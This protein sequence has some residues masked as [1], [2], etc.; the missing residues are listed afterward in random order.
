MRMPVISGFAKNI[1]A[2]RTLATAAATVVLGVALP[3]LSGGTPAWACGDP[4]LDGAKDVPWSTPGVN[5]ASKFLRNM[6]SSISADGKWHEIA[7]EL[8]N[9]TG[10]GYDNA[11]PT[12]GF[13]DPK[14]DLLRG[15][16]IQVQA[17]QGDDSRRSLPL[18]PGCASLGEVEIDTS[19]LGQHIDNNGAALYRFLVKL[20]PNSSAS[21]SQL[22]V[23]TDGLADHTTTGGSSDLAT[24]QVEHPDATDP[25]P[26][27]G[28]G[29]GTGKP[30]TK[31]SGKPTAKPTESATP[32]AAPVAATSAA[33]SSAPTAEPSGTATT[34]GTERLA[35]TGGGDTSWTLVAAGSALLASG[36]AAL[37]FARRRAAR[38]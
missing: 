25:S 32:T 21:L 18:L 2:R 20:S 35:Y 11:R 4:R 34:P 27:P 16:D 33:P 29:T 10:H 5:P 30:T 3:V 9:Q 24:L 12:L 23:V 26:A 17:W 7:I 14:H 13:A 38:R 15:K 28:S 31:P 22:V 36:A 37:A 19:S 8:R 1:P 6:P